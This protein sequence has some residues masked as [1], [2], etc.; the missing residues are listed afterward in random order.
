MEK[1]PSIDFGGTPVNWSNVLSK[2]VI[3]YL[4]DVN[5]DLGTSN[6]PNH[7]EFLEFLQE[8][9]DQKIEIIAASDI[10]MTS[11]LHD[12]DY[13]S[14]D[15][16]KRNFTRDCFISSSFN[17]L[18]SIVGSREKPMTIFEAREKVDEN[19]IVWGVGKASV[20]ML[21]ENYNI[22]KKPKK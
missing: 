4:N 21:G 6:D 16:V 5:P 13:H 14:N 12:I 1:V 7:N 22:K 17:I 11:E 9:D 8:L 3:D 18:K 2:D 19:N 10:S 15:E 20:E